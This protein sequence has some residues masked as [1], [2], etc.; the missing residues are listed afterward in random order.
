MNELYH[1]NVVRIL[2][3]CSLRHNL[4]PVYV[5]L[6]NKKVHIPFC[7]VYKITVARYPLELHLVHRNI[8]DDT[9]QEALTHENGM[10]VLGFKFK[11]VD[12]ED[13]QYNLFI[14]LF[15]NIALTEAGIKEN[16]LCMESVLFLY[17]SNL[18]WELFCP[19]CQTPSLIPSIQKETVG[20][21]SDDM[22]K[23]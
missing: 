23:C 7:I 22:R 9:V 4:P 2:H 1:L 10:T 11:I 12:D 13:V 3:S 6:M 16:A 19:S 15:T 8:H 5:E 14:Q 21:V 20:M 18:N 17:T